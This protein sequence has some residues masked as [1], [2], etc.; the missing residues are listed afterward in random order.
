MTSTRKFKLTE[1]ARSLIDLRLLLENGYGSIVTAEGKK[2]SMR[3]FEKG[4]KH[5]IFV[6]HKVSF[7]FCSK[8][9]VGSK[10]SRRLE[11]MILQKNHLYDFI[12]F[13]L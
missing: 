10:I 12:V 7:W 3:H 4:K 1:F 13:P 9:N 2:I 6:F 11:V 5:K 8:V